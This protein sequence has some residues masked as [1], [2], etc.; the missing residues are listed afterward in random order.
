MRYAPAPSAW[1][2]WAVGETSRRIIF[3]AHIVNYLATRDAKTG[4]TD[5]YYEPLDDEMIWNMPLPCSAAAWNAQTEQEWLSV[6]Q[7]QDTNFVTD[8]QSVLL[9][10]VFKH[11]PTI[12]VLITKFTKDHIRSQFAGNIGFQDSES[13]RN[14]VVRCALKQLF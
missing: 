14:L 6:L 12:K 1:L 3:L 5:P 8:S 7:K 11:E 10:E 9:S 4:E 2:T 13:F